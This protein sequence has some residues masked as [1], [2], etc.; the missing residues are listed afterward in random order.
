MS[1]LTQYPAGKRPAAP[2]ISGELINGGTLDLAEWRGE[3]IVINVWGSWCAPCRVEAPGLQKV[4]D[5]TR[6]MG[7]RFVGFDTRDND[8][9]AQAFEKSY[10]ITYPSIRDR[11]GTLLLRFEGRIPVSAVPSTVMIDRDGKIAARIIG[12]ASYA[13]LSSL[14]K[15]LAAEKPSVRTSK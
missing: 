12:A 7:V 2:Q 4:F 10:G 13:T 9:A 6:S 14:V 11:D 1:G 3:V 8:A 5:E 15:D